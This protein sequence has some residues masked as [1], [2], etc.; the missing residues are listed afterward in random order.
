M[1]C[2][3]ASRGVLT[4]PVPLQYLYRRTFQAFVEMLQSLV[5]KDRHLENLDIIFKVNKISGENG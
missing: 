4:N 3:R 1:Q 2:G 5:I